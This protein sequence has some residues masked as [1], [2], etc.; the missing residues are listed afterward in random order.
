MP[1]AVVL[2]LIQI[3]SGAGSA[4]LSIEKLVA[5]AKSRGDSHLNADETSQVHALVVGHLQTVHGAYDEM[6]QLE[7]NSGA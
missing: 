7:E 1:I 4:A 3:L 2:Q 5:A 6:S